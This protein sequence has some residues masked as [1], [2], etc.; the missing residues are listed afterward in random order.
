MLTAQ[1][2]LTALYQINP[3][4]VSAIITQLPFVALVIWMVWQFQKWYSA[5]EEKNRS[6]IEEIDRRWRQELKEIRQENDKQMERLFD[7]FNT[8]YTNQLANQRGSYLDSLIEQRT[9][10]SESLTRMEAKITRNSDII[11]L[12]VQ[13]MSVNTAAVTEIAKMDDL[14]ELLITRNNRDGAK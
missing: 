4:D 5:A 8:N 2:F 11:E 14:V 7:T 9:F 12:L 3:F 1:A 13:Q 6:Y 10:Y